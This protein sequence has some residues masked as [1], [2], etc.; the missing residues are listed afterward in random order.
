MDVVVDCLTIVMVIL[1]RAIQEGG[2]GRLQLDSLAFGLWYPS[3]MCIVDH[4][5]YH[6]YEAAG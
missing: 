3:G 1:V 5:V 4:A 6:L 2:A